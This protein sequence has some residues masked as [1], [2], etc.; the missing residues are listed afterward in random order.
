MRAYWKDRA[1]ASSTGSI[2]EYK[3]G[4]VGEDRI[5][6]LKRFLAVIASDT[7]EQCIY[8]ETGKEAGFIYPA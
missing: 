7:G 3:V 1:G 6:E 5:P 8:L 2:K 4:L